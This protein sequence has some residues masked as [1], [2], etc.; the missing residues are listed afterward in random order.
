MPNLSFRQKQIL[1]A[2]FTFLIYTSI[3]NWKAALLLLV[4]VGFHEYSHLWA[5]KRMHLRTSGFF[6]IP[7]MGGVALVSDR[8][9]TYGQQAFVVLLGPV[10]GG[11]LAGVTA[12]AYYL[13]GYPYLASAA[14]WMC[15]LNLFN[16]LPLSFLDGGQLLD[17]LTYSTNRTFGMVMHIISTVVAAVV[18]WF[19]NY[20]IAIMVI[21]FGGASIWREITDWN[22]PKRL[23]PGQMFLTTAG[24]SATI[25]LLGQLYF[26]LKGM[27]GVGFA[28]IF[29]R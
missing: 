25:F 22:P 21:L 20:L 5:A 13:T 6:F 3:L 24:W 29:G 2:I 17:T 11:L 18:L 1:S 15:F 14:Y 8:Y 28:A 19:F 26:F 23:T 7:F 10:G 4:G 16:L 12:G 27:P 9:K